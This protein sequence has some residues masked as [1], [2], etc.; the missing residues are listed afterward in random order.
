MP[1]TFTWLDYSER[2]R[3]RAIQVVDLFHMPGTVDELGVGSVRDALADLLTPGTSTI[4]TRARYFLFLPWIFRRLEER[5]VA[6][7]KAE[8]W[9]RDA[10]VRLM[11]AVRGSADAEGLIGV[12]VGRQVKRLGSSVYWAGLGTYGS[13]LYR[14]SQTQYF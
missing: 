10:E 14:G 7:S 3:Q 11:D 13:R 1:S 5:G 12:E 2:D 4:Q 9:V 6:A 8:G